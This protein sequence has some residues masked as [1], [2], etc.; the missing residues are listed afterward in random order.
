MKQLLLVEL[1]A[2][3]S[4]VKKEPLTDSGGRDE[5]RRSSIYGNV[6]TTDFPLVS[7]ALCT[8]NGAMYLEEQLD[9]ILAQHYRPLELVVVDDV[10]T[11]DTW[12]LLNE[13]LKN[14]DDIFVTLRRNRYN[15]GYTKN[16][17]KAISMCKGEFIAL[18][19]QDDIWSPDKISTLFDNVEEHLL[20]YHDS[21]FVD[22]NGEDLEIR[23]SDLI[24]MYEGAGSR[25]L[26]LSNCVSG[27]SCMFHKRLINYIFPIPENVFHDWWIAYQATSFGTIAYV[28]QPLVH[29]RRHSA[30]NTV[31]SGNIKSR[32]KAERREKRL[33]ALGVNQHE[34]MHRSVW[35]SACADCVWN[36]DRVFA[37]KMSSVLRGWNSKLINIRAFFLLSRYRNQL[38]VISK[39]GNKN[40]LNYIFE[41]FFWGISAKRMW[42]HMLVRLGRRS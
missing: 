25:P 32:S 40:K 16:F 30:N 9:S 12:M 42:Y 17:E 2:E 13:K 5:K 36:P 38:F 39:I 27:H 18:S 11:D 6:N 34:G 31:F 21:E 15:L 41:R 28:D 37:K 29:Y 24:N 14:V 23:M 10:S 1:E 19:D 35:L 26:L 20:V 7:I 3:T 33:K 8:Y 4:N 22:K